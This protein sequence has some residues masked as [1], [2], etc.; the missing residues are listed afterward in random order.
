MEERAN[1][2]KLLE[3]IDITEP[4][5]VPWETMS[6]DERS[7]FC[8]MCKKN[9][10]NISEMT[11]EEAEK[12]LQQ[13][14]GLACL[15]FFRREDG[16]IVTDSC[17]RILRG[18]RNFLRVIRQAVAVVIGVVLSAS[19]SSAQGS[20][21]GQKFEKQSS[22]PVSTKSSV[23]SK[24]RVRQ[25]FVADPI[26]PWNLLQLT[27]GDFALSLE[28]EVYMEKEKLFIREDQPLLK[29]ER[30]PASDKKRQGRCLGDFTVAG[31]C[32]RGKEWVSKHN[33]Q[34]A[35]TYFKLALKLAR[36]YPAKESELQDVVQ[37]YSDLLRRTRRASE[38]EQLLK[39][40][41]PAAIAAEKREFHDRVF[42][43]MQRH[44]QPS[45]EQEP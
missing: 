28:S 11:S 18:A 5:Q 10:Y 16:T 4:C 1:P 43:N 25:G 9:V 12:F 3:V 6:G 13:N 36:W 14:V 45:S 37:Q 26:A 7:R 41:I 38:A 2:R 32:L 22:G 39:R 33:D 29:T 42:K 34:I 17:P 15:R 27:T 44:S 35:E 21:T 31:A 20:K 40:G 30:R 8:R 19:V 23:R 24:Y